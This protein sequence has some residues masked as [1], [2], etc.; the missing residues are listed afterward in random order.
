MIL[1]S[2]E[3]VCLFLH[4][5][6]CTIRS[7]RAMLMTAAIPPF[8]ILNGATEGCRGLQSAPGESR[9]LAVSSLENERDIALH[10]L[11][12]RSVSCH[13]WPVGGSGEDECRL[14]VTAVDTLETAKARE[15]SVF[16]DSAIQRLHIF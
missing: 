5:S 4:P 7:P 1:L 16:S 2:I 14:E 11:N 13:S 6:S 15:P 8:R 12:D 3:H 9:L 10:S